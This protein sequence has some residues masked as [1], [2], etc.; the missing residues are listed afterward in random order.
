MVTFEGCARRMG[1]I[2]PFLEKIGLGDLEEA[3]PS[4]FPQDDV[5]KLSREF[6]DRIRERCLGIYAWCGGGFEG[7]SQ[8]SG[9]SCRK[10]R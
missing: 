8:N 10:D 1:Q 9:G 4:A 2:E 6:S 7:W 5:E 3:S